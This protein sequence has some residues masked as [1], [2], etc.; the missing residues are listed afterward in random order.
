[1][2]PS[3]LSNNRMSNNKKKYVSSLPPKEKEYDP[4]FS[5]QV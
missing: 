4:T 1:M 5:R 2:I 3:Q